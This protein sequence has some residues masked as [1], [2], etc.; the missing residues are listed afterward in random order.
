MI[1]RD[2]NKCKMDYMFDPNQEPQF[3]E[4]CQYCHEIMV[5]IKKA[6]QKQCER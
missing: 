4:I 5:E 6:K 2:C 1:I 3:R